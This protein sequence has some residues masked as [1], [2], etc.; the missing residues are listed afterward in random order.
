M[1]KK[2]WKK[3][4]KNFKKNQKTNFSKKIL[5]KTVVDIFTYHSTGTRH[6]LEQSSPKLV[7]ERQ[8]GLKDT[9]KVEGIITL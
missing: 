2:I 4:K 6:K 5:K 8:N 7:I 9:K 1:K 3:I